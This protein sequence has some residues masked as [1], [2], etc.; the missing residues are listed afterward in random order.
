MQSM[1]AHPQPLT[2]QAAERIQVLRQRLLNQRRELQDFEAGRVK[3]DQAIW[4]LDRM[5]SLLKSTLGDQQ[6]HS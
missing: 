3:L 1:D 6:D 4:A 5:L 2:Q